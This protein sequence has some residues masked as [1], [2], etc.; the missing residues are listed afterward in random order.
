MGKFATPIPSL[1]T[2]VIRMSENVFVVSHPRSGTHL[3]IDTLLNNFENVSHNWVDIDRLTSRYR[4]RVSTKKVKNMIVDDHTVIKSHMVPDVANYFENEPEYVDFVQELASKSKMI[5]MLRDGRDVMVSFYYFMHYIDK[6]QEKVPFSDFLRNEIPY[7]VLQ[8]SN[9]Q[10]LNPVE[11]WVSHVDSWLDQEDVLL[12]QFEEL[13]EDF[14]NTLL[15]VAGYVDFPLKNKVVCPIRD[16]KVTY[17]S[18]L[19]SLVVGTLKV[20]YRRL[21][22]ETY[23]TSI[24][25]RKGRTGDYQHHFSDEDLEF[26]NS[27]A[28]EAMERAGYY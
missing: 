7:E 14:Y 2:F 12:V 6:N 24:Y 18:K 1:P 10:N 27:I 25:F 9:G 19:V 11:F 16:D 23:D 13:R 8:F 28:L 20:I 5:Y 21:F 17:N 4:K 22:T 26:F 3:M 15:R